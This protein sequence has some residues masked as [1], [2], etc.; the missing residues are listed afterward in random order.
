MF[1][2]ISKISTIPTL[3]F[4][5]AGCQNY[6][7]PKPPYSKVETLSVTDLSA[8][9]VTFRGNFI[10]LGD[11]AEIIDHG[12][13]WGFGEHVTQEGNSEGTL[14]LGTAS[15]NGEFQGNVVSGLQNDTT[16]YVKAFVVTSAYKVYGAPVTFRK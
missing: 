9:G 6:E 13:V 16:Y 2:S 4:F 14:D 1:K 11:T 12:F 15:F 7:F 8:G 10:R 3:V 5:L